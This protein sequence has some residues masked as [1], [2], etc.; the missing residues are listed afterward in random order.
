M[1]LFDP[2][3][4]VEF[5]M[6]HLVAGYRDRYQ[7]Y[8]FLRPGFDQLEELSWANLNAPMTLFL[9]ALL[10]PLWLWKPSKSRKMLKLND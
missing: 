6:I 2:F 10:P 1:M 4:F 8:F 9:I 5:R 3:C 7:S